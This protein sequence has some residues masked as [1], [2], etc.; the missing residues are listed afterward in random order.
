VGIAKSQDGAAA[1][2]ACG[3]AAVNLQDE[4]ALIFTLGQQQAV[5]VGAAAGSHCEM[6]QGGAQLLDRL[7]Q[8]LVDRTGHL[9]G[10][11]GG[12]AS[13]SQGR[14]AADSQDGA[15]TGSQGLAG[16]GSQVGVAD[17][18]GKGQPQVASVVQLL[19]AKPSSCFHI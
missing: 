15:A 1:G 18:S 19:V 14:G 7:G 17:G 12:A 9:A 2:I 5:R 16:A 3:A 10:S 8:Q 4:T 11:Q 6:S 13:G